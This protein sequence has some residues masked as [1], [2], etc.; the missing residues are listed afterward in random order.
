[1]FKLKLIP[2][3]ENYFD[4]FNEMATHIH[5]SAKLLAE[6][7]NDFERAEHYIHKIKYLEHQCDELTHTVVKRLNQTFFTPI[8]RE[9]IYALAKALDDVIDLIDAV[10]N[11]AMLYRVTRVPEAARKQ[12]DVIVR[13][14]AQ[15]MQAVPKIKTH[16]GMQQYF[17][18][19]HTL[20]NEGDSLFREAVA[21]LF[22]DHED[23]LEV[24][25]WK[26]LYET[27]EKG[28]DKCEDVANVLESVALKNA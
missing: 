23:P 24:I 15:I 13:A 9:D 4:L 10:A 17:I 6:F 20:E 12:A 16:A 14:T 5:A 28:I 8:D 27:L 3:E 26:D 7:F 11:H 18:E 2:Q 21:Q 19:I 22:Q 1:M 25:K